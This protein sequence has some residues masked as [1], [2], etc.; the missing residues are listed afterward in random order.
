[1]ECASQDSESAYH[2]H[3]ASDSIADRT[4]SLE[5][6]SNGRAGKGGNESGLDKK[7]DISPR[8]MGS[9]CENLIKGT[10]V[11]VT[12]VNVEPVC[13]KTRES[14]ESDLPQDSNSEDD[15]KLTVK[16]NGVD[17]SKRSS[18]SISSDDDDVTNGK[19]VSE[20]FNVENFEGNA[21]IS[22]K[23]LEKKIRFEGLSVS[24]DS[25]QAKVSSP[26]KFSDVLKSESKSTEDIDR[27]IKSKELISEESETSYVNIS[28]ENSPQKE[29]RK[30]QCDLNIAANE[31]ASSHTVLESQSSCL[32]NVNT[33][34]EA[35]PGQS[36]SNG[37]KCPLSSSV[38][39]K[40]DPVQL[41][42]ITPL[43]SRETTPTHTQSDSLLPNKRR[44]RGSSLC[45]KCDSETESENDVSVSKLNLRRRIV[46]L[47]ESASCENGSFGLRNR[48]QAGFSLRE[49]KSAGARAG[50]SS[51]GETEGHSSE[52]SRGSRR[53]SSQ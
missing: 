25:T 53:V 5:Q 46:K 52:Y 45:E 32:P 16:T 39:F 17:K 27:E 40:K 14:Q 24:D 48:K 30:D 49:T 8:E 28:V 19:N 31:I 33:Q 1:M 34:V 18:Q 7:L 9:G 51:E 41:R 23:D 43:S 36:Q 50:S 29:S 38:H 10:S 11:T 21:G 22:K 26:G 6:D 15:K 13:C 35:V 37:P 3:E 12:S 47:P 44:L 2:T 42:E 4:S 20:G